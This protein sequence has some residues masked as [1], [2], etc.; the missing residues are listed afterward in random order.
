MNIKFKRTEFIL[1][2]FLVFTV[3]F[4]Q[5]NASLLNTIILYLQL[6]I[7]YVYTK[8]NRWCILLTNKLYFIMPIRAEDH[9][10][11]GSQKYSICGEKYFGF[12][13]V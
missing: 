7:Y 2:V 12:D 8:N 9:F 4:D 11:T 1:Y 3:T 10:I 13:N 6:F 5:F